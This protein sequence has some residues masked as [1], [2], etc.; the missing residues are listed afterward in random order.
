MGT[1]MKYS[2]TYHPQTEGRTEVTNQSSGT[3]VGDLIKPHAK[4]RDLLLPLT[5]FAYNKAPSKATSLSPFKLVY[6]IDPLSQLD[7]ILWSSGQKPSVDT[8][9]RVEEL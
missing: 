2:T 6:G 5:E 3:L 7:L 4:A 9:K 8:A 1:K